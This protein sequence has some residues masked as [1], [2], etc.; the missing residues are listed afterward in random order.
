MESNT[1]T[2]SVRAKLC[3]FFQRRF[4]IGQRIFFH[5]EKNGFFVASILRV[6][7]LPAN[8]LQRLDVREKVYSKL[9]LVLRVS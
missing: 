2:R 1:S 9:M 8:Y 7:V 6:F 4:R 3:K 5:T